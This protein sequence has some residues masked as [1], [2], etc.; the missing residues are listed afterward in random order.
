MSVRIAIAAV[1]CVCVL[2]PRPSLAE[3]YESPRGFRLELPPHWIALNQSSVSDTLDAIEQHSE[4]F[5]RV[6]EPTIVSMRDMVSEGSI[7]HFFDTTTADDGLPGTHM[8]IIIGLGAVPSNARELAQNER[9]MEQLCSML[10]ELASRP[11]AIRDRR[12]TYLS[13]RLASAITFDSMIE[14]VV[15]TQYLVPVSPATRAEI[16]VNCREKD[17]E[18]SWPE[19]EEI[20]SSF[21]ITEAID[22]PFITSFEGTIGVTKPN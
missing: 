8:N 13:G 6:A 2:L 1:V 16:T 19:V 10:E 15:T 9:E 21:E 5:G 7:E 14:G 17:L 12:F 20:L 22:G 3:T 4:V 11:L 18:S